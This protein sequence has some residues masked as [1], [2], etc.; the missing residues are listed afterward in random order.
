[1][2]T[3]RELARELSPDNPGHMV[4]TISGFL[5][6]LTRDEL[7]TALTDSLTPEDEADVRAYFS[8][9]ARLGDV[10]ETQQ[11]VRAAETALGEAI[12]VR[13]AAIRDALA[14]GVAAA[15]IADALGIHRSRVY[16]IRGD[17]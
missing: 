7:Q 15:A 4:E 5:G 16:Q 1:M 3:I 9:D 8:T 10:L 2:T 6:H 17:L 12:T 11:A 14:E 13:D